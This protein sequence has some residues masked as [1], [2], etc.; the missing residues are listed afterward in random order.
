[1]TFA[2][3]Q[4][5]R[6]RPALVAIL[7]VTTAT[8]APALTLS[9]TGHENG[10]IDQAYGD[11]VASTPQDGHYYGADG[12]FTPNIEVSYGPAPDAEPGI[13]YSGY[14]D[15]L[16]TLYDGNSGFGLLEITLHADSAWVV[17][18]HGFDLA[19]FADSGP[20][21][22][23]KVWNEDGTILHSELDVELT[24]DGHDEIRFDP[25]LRSSTLVI[26]LDSSNLGTQSPWAGIDNI[27]F[28]QS[29]L[30]VPT[31]STSWS[32]LKASFDGSAR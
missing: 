10:D 5:R 13:H 26:G 6:L 12:G 23:V 1:M 11:R 32:S 28:S 25:P 14:G 3:P 17:S 30:T 2:R 16:W 20:I 8:A 4:V 9:F 15:L 7:A 21:N 19:M 29:A 31:G 27:Y 18:L 22:S 24:P